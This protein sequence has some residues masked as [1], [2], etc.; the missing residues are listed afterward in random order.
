MGKWGEELKLKYAK[1]F[2]KNKPIN[3]DGTK[4][5]SNIKILIDLEQIERGR[6]IASTY[7][8]F[9]EETNNKIFNNLQVVIESTSGNENYYLTP[10]RSENVINFKKSTVPSDW[11]KLS[12]YNEK[13]SKNFYYYEPSIFDKDGKYVR[14]F[15]GHSSSGSISI[16][17]VRNTIAENMGTIT[18]EPSSLTVSEYEEMLKDLYNIHISLLVSDESPEKIGIEGKETL[19][20]ILDNVNELEEAMQGIIK[21]PNKNLEL[22]QGSKSVKQINKFDPKVEIQKKINPGRNFYYISQLS[23]TVAT[24]ENYLIKQSLTDLLNYLNMSKNSLITEC[25]NTRSNS[26]EDFESELSNIELEKPKISDIDSFSFNVD[27]SSNSILKSTPRKLKSFFS[28]KQGTNERLSYRNATIEVWCFRNCLKSNFMPFSIEFKDNN[29]RD[30]SFIRTNTLTSNHVLSHYLLDKFGEIIKKISTTNDASDKNISVEAEIEIFNGFRKVSK[31]YNIFINNRPIAS[32]TSDELKHWLVSRD[33]YAEDPTVDSF[34]FKTSLRQREK[35]KMNQINSIKQRISIANDGIKVIERLLDK[36]LFKQIELTHRVTN[37]PTQ[38]FLHNPFYIRA[39]N[40][41]Q[42]IS[43]EIEVTI[44]VKEEKLRLGVLYLPDIFETWTYFKI[45]HLLS[46]NM[47][48]KLENHS[49]VKKKIITY[50]QDESDNFDKQRNFENITMAKLSLRNFQLIVTYEPRLHYNVNNKIENH[51]L[52]PDILFEFYIDHE[53]VGDAI[54][55]VKFR[56][57]ETPMNWWEDIKKVSIEKYI[58]RLDDKVDKSYKINKASIK[59]SSIIHSDTSLDNYVYFPYDLT[60]NRLSESNRTH[61]GDNIINRIIGDLKIFYEG[62]VVSKV[63]HKFSSLP[64]TPHHTY[65]FNNWLRMMMEFHFG[66]AEVCWSCGN[67]QNIE[68]ETKWTKGGAR[69]YNLTCS[70]CHEFWVSTHCQ[71]CTNKI[72]KHIENYHTTASRDF[73]DRWNI[74]CPHC[75]HSFSRKDALNEFN[76]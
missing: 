76:F 54:M 64:F 59:N 63:P 9:F 69:A 75:F 36:T 53:K 49:D 37:V 2:Y 11:R 23:K 72:Y 55:D 13:K 22:I 14:N 29:K 16:F 31:I 12:A 60:G 68:K 3:A 38:L 30:N 5:L 19:T 71:N 28:M 41:L 51:L 50:Y 1:V 74:R 17:R 18:F 8:K 44:Y 70:N 35:N 58:L 27:K 24:N 47:G 40:S 43:K 33:Y 65:T 34:R 46:T 6:W 7:K 57:Y 62:G 56:K 20:K 10:K 42:N 26:N 67:Y 21:N 52:T 45:L 73:R 48:W 66:E 39:W 25:T 61:N 4:D 15:I 32:P